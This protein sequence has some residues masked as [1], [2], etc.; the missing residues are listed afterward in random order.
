MNKIFK[1]IKN[2]YTYVS[3]FLKKIFN[4]I[5]HYGS[6][7]KSI[8]IKYGQNKTNILS[9]NKTRIKGPE[10]CICHAPYRSLYI[11]RYGVATACCFN[12]E[13]K[14]GKFPE[15]SISD[16]I[17]GA[18]R[19]FLQEKLKDN[20]FI[21]GC[22]HCLKLIESGN[23]EGVEARLYDSLKNNNRKPS[24]I[25]FELDNICNLECV[26][27]H[28]GFSSSIAKRKNIEVV[29]NI[30]NQ[31]FLNQLKP[32]IS[33]LQVAKFLG[34]EPFL[35]N[36]YYQ[37]WDLIL[38]IN[39]RCIINLQTN[40]TIF[41]DKIKYYLQRGNFYIGMSIDSLNKQNFEAIRVNANFNLVM[42]NFYEF[43]KISKQKYNYINISVCPMQQNWHEIPDILEFCNKNKV[44]I[45]FNTVYTRGFAIS[46][47][48]YDK[49]YE[50]IEY[51]KSIKLYNNGLIAKRNNRFFRDLIQQIETVYIKKYNLQKYDIKK[52]K[53]NYDM[54]LN[55]F[56][57]TY[58]SL[59]TDERDEKF[60]KI[61]EGL[62]GEFLLSDN[63]I[64]SLNNISADIM[65]E[66]IN[67]KSI[68]EIRQMLKSYADEG[69]F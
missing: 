54:L 34:G 46:E 41:N 53:W 38:D 28:E 7:K 64:K 1:T 68:I 9:Y 25:I 65:I 57:E 5:F 69:N 21:Y 2:I 15:S 51:Y 31:E 62:E 59:L 16:I 55:H 45:Y 47:Y 29:P 24:E 30:Y 63:N 42:R 19:Q 17:Y 6:L 66:T 60:K 33:Q 3:R 18:K 8:A 35:I 14:L 44:F 48:E 32:Y 40:G 23:F 26:M 50:I 61:F 10:T 12:R 36:I 58:S 22:Q 4:Y 43:L 20:N 11:D 56:L 67:T 37:I 49:L 39:P 13:N 52:H 27:C